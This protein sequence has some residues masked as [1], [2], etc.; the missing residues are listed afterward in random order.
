MATQQ[1][2]F[3]VIVGVAASTSCAGWY[4]VEGVVGERLKLKRVK[5]WSPVESNDA[6][7]R[8]ATP[9]EESA[10]DEVVKLADR[11][12]QRPAVAAPPAVPRPDSVAVVEPTDHQSGLEKLWTRFFEENQ[13][14]FSYESLSV[15]IDIDGTRHLYTPDFI[16]RDMRLV[17]EIKPARPLQSEYERSA[18]C[19]RALHGLGLTHVMICGAPISPVC[20]PVEEGTIAERFR[21]GRY[22]CFVFHCSE[23]G[24][25]TT[26]SGM[27]F[28]LNTHNGTPAPVLTSDLSIHY[29]QIPGWKAVQYPRTTKKRGRDSDDDDSSSATSASA[30]ASSGDPIEIDV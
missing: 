27:F 30:S 15:A 21:A 19:A 3:L 22:E 6:V 16:L 17:V 10:R 20:C 24:Q 14:R 28:A 13:I 8:R 25:V 7:V 29:N 26:S 11:T 2:A 23:G 12:N 4:I 5:A 9:I 1:R 18:G